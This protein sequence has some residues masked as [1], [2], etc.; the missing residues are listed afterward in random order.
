MISKEWRGPIEKIVPGGCAVK[1]KS[2]GSKCSGG[3]IQNTKRCWVMISSRAASRVGFEKEKNKDWIGRRFNLIEGG[4][5]KSRRKKKPVW[6]E[7]SIQRGG[8]REV[9]KPQKSGKR[10]NL[11]KKRGDN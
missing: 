5:E 11:E 9:R 6:H 10:W 2:R 3:K 8:R 7:E 4:K 1:T